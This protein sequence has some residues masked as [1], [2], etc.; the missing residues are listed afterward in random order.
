MM[1]DAARKKKHCGDV[2]NAAYE[3]IKRY[4]LFQE[5]AVY[6]GAQL[7]ETGNAAKDAR[8]E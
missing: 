7:E 3:K 1:G 2:R 8:G 6:Y 5:M 4:L